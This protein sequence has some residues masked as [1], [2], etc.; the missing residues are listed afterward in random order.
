[1]ISEGAW[2]KIFWNKI[3]SL[4][5]IIFRLQLK[6]Q[7]VSYCSLWFIKNFKSKYAVLIK[8]F[9]FIWNILVYFIKIIKFVSSVGR[10][11]KA[12]I[13][14]I[15]FFAQ[16]T[17][18]KI[19]KNIMRW[20]ITRHLKGAMHMLFEMMPMRRSEEDF[21]PLS[22]AALIMSPQQQTSS[23]EQSVRQS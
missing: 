19:F 22:T 15:L 1:M 23:R 5:I 6:I 16:P 3:A 7:K 8:L 14:K 4:N 17:N 10:L 9:V 20:Q 2:N 11:K 12:P 18:F 21:L 13:L